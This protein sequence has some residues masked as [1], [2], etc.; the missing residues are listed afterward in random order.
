MATYEMGRRPNMRYVGTFKFS[1]EILLRLIQH[2]DYEAVELRMERLKV[3]TK[4]MLE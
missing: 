1:M 4:I 2:G 3:L